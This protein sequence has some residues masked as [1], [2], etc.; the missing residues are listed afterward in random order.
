MLHIFLGKMKFTSAYNAIH[1]QRTPPQSFMAS[2]ENRTALICAE[3]R[4]VQLSNCQHNA[5]W[6]RG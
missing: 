4:N 6:R 2:A 3:S 1:T 5:V